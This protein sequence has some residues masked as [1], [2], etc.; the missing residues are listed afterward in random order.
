MVFII[1]IIGII[2]ALPR[3]SNIWSI[4]VSTYED[5][6]TLLGVFF[7]YFSHLLLTTS[8]QTIIIAIMER[9]QIQIQIRSQT[10]TRSE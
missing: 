6:G 3:T 2:K 8:P 1:N 9:K 4:K 10:Q 5:S 7:M